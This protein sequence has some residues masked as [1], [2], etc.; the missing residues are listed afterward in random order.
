MDLSLIVLRANDPAALAEFYS[1]LG[2]TFREERH[3][4]GPSHMAS[5][6]GRSIVEIYPR[7]SEFDATDAV[8]LGF[9]VADLDSVCSEAI[10]GHGE[11]LSAPRQSAWGRRAVIRDPAGHTIELVQ[12]V[13]LDASSNREPSGQL[14]LTAASDRLT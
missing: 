8:R 13:D 12:S 11:V 9:T 14:A 7:Q 10:K 1:A 5:V 3:G 4:A 2:M 6:T